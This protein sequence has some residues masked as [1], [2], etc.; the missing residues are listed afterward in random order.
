[1][2]FENCP[3][4]Y[5]FQSSKFVFVLFSE[6]VTCGEELP[7]PLLVLPPHVRLLTRELRLVLVDQVHQEEPVNISYIKKKFGMKYVY[8]SGRTWKKY[9]RNH[10]E[11]S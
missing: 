6:A 4:P 1:M 9:Y 11:F 8:K 2:R 7:T 10:V 3:N 5:T